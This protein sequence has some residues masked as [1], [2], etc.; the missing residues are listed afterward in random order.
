MSKLAIGLYSGEYSQKLLADKPI[1][2]DADKPQ[3]DEFY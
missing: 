3:E 2:A 1:E